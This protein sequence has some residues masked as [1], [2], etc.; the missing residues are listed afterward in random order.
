MRMLLYLILL[1]GF[2]LAGLFT[3]GWILFGLVIAKVIVVLLT[4][5]E[6]FRIIGKVKLWITFVIVA[7]VLASFFSYRVVNEDSPYD[8]EL[9]DLTENNRLL[10]IDS[11][12]PDTIRVNQDGKTHV[13]KERLIKSVDSAY[14]HY[15]FQFKQAHVE[16]YSFDA[17]RADS[18]QQEK[19]NAWKQEITEQGGSIKPAE[20][21]GQ[22]HEQAWL[23][24]V[25]QQSGLLYWRDEVLYN[26][27]T[28][29]SI[30]Q[31]S[32]E[33][34]R[35]LE[36]ILVGYLQ[37]ISELKLEHIEDTT[38]RRTAEAV[39]GDQKQIFMSITYYPSSS[40][41]KRE[42]DQ[43]YEAHQADYLPEMLEKV[44]E[45]DEQKQ[46]REIGRAS[47]RERV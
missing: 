40:Y 3:E 7:L 42:L 10:P 41:G 9:V 19:L 34:H 33:S 36:S 5:R 1:F 45:L 26:I 30:A 27:R 20:G 39:Y 18:L 46:I 14:S 47:C 25:D 15:V 35:I 13:Y 21:L 32:S 11:H 8:L 4:D 16:L 37:S 43:E 23:Y 28:P 31:W 44:K 22:T 2:I 29:Y 17:V 24:Q 12:F 6:V 38:I